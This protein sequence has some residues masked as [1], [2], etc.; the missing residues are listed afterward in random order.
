MQ[1]PSE[2]A[3]SISGVASPYSVQQF[4]GKYLGE[5]P[6]LARTDGTDLAIKDNWYNYAGC[7]H[8]DQHLAIEEFVREAA[9]STQP[10]ARSLNSSQSL[11]AASLF[12]ENG[13]AVVIVC[14][15][16]GPTKIASRLVLNAVDAWRMKCELES[17]RQALDE[18]AM[19]LAQSFE[20]QNWLRSFARNASS[21]SRTHSANDIASH[22]LKP[23]G[24]LLRAQDFFLIVNSDESLRCGLVDSS[25]GTSQ[26]S[27]EH[28]RS[29]LDRLGVGPKSPPV[30]KNNICLQTEAGMVRSI[31]AVAVAGSE[32]Y[33][34]HLVG[35]NRGIEQH[36][37][38]LPF[39][40]PEFGSGDVG[41][42]QEAA[43][44]LS[45]QVHNIR[46][47]LQSNQLTLGTLHVMSSAI[48]AR[49]SYTQGHSER[50][51]RL[52]FELAEI[53]GLSTEACQEIYLSGILH[54][55]GKIGIPDHV[56]LKNGSLTEEEYKVIQQH[57]QIGYR[58]VEQLGHLQFV[59]P[60]ILYH[61]ERWDGAGYPHGLRGESIPLMARI[62]AVADAFDAMTSSRPYRSAM[63]VENALSIVRSGSNHQWDAQ[64][65]ECFEIW[66]K[67]RL[68]TIDILQPAIHS[69]IPQTSPDAQ[70]YQA[71]MALGN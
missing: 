28:I 41:L 55:I 36:N 2:S 40:D 15:Q 21:F 8:L 63:P 43:V 33:I 38:S 52:S 37:E 61:H 47:L 58:I 11:I 42:L 26:F 23:L 66:I 67:K 46:L 70:I 14:V 6:L 64:A 30:V 69:I 53:Y 45:T 10:I 4:L 35:I 59:L 71:V 51:A 9:A 19:Q 16:D 18:S 57:P 29:V 49:D 25:Y 3:L 7:K 65:V 22:I 48:D 32:H 54:D 5:V 24:Y 17:S 31:I 1:F 44:L 62:M 20:E 34:G 39:Y 56:L 13:G 60:G 68:S 50:V 27:I 12:D